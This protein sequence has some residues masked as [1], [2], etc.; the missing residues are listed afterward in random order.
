[1]I[2]PDE[3][4]SG[5]GGSGGFGG[6]GAAVGLGLLEATAM[7]VTA[8][9]SFVIDGL[10]PAAAMGITGAGGSAKSTMVLWTMI[11]I[12]CGRRVFGKEVLRS[13]GCVFVTAEDERDMVLYRA[14]QMC[15]ALELDEE[16]M[17]K[18]A[19]RLFI[20]DV[21]GSVCRLV[22]SKAGGNLGYSL[23]VDRLIE[24]YRGLGVV[25]IAFDPATFFGAGE[26]FVNDGEAILMS[27]GRRISAALGC[28]TAFVHH[29]GKDAGR[30]KALDQYSGRGGSAFADNSRAMWSMARYDRGDKNVGAIPEDI[31]SMIDEGCDV[32]RLVVTKMSY[33]AKPNRTLWIGRD[34][35]NPWYF[36]TEWSNPADIVRTS[37]EEK[38]AADVLNDIMLGKVVAELSAQRAQGKFPSRRSMR[39]ANIVLDD[40]TRLSEKKIT[41]SIDDGIVK[42]RIDELDL[43]EHLVRGA[44]KTFLE[45]IFCTNSA[46]ISKNEEEDLV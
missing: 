44:R 19:S 30:S 6:S 11:H 13:G 25:F 23:A 18:V 1:M 4:G 46:P 20:E 45:P 31:K 33:G 40:G 14:A 8:P 41:A 27:A 43:P 26:R 24:A 16:E 28:C 39:N 38:D 32:S 22:E 21:S 15:K 3:G 10:M 7:G 12:C 5:V 2:D 9:Y 29:V 35:V 36:H 42:G 37:K 17:A 34:G